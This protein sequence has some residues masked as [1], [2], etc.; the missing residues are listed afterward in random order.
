MRPGLRSASPPGSP[1]LPGARADL[2]GR[3]GTNCVSRC[4]R[5][6]HR[7]PPARRA[8]DSHTHAH[9]PL[10]TPE[11]PRAA[12]CS[13]EEGKGIAGSAPF[14]PSRHPPP[15]A[16]GR[17]DG[18]LTPGPGLRLAGRGSEP[19]AG[20]D[21][22]NLDKGHSRLHVSPFQL[23]LAGS[24]SVCPPATRGKG[25]RGAA[26]PREPP[27]PPPSPP[28]SLPSS[29][30]PPPLP[31]PMT[32]DPGINS[33]SRR[34]GRP[35]PTRCRSLARSPANSPAPPPPRL[36]AAAA[37][38]GAAAS[39]AR[40]SRSASL[41]LRLPDSP[42]RT[43]RQTRRPN[44]HRAHWRAPSA[45]PI[46]RTD[47]AGAPPGQSVAMEGGSRGV[48]SLPTCG[49]AGRGGENSLFSRCPRG[50]LGTS[51]F[52]C[53]Y[54]PPPPARLPTSAPRGG[55]GP[56]PGAAPRRGGL[57][58]SS[59]LTWRSGEREGKWEGCRREDWRAPGGAALPL[60]A[61][62]RCRV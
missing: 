13:G 25:T 22:A 50:G 26:A 8:P 60:P 2:S 32:K 34:R 20:L 53:C 21:G 56:G 9:L 51:R 62:R 23:S 16:L 43:E 40:R 49:G 14:S 31:S 6:A 48:V 4:P 61:R 52:P 3:R 46:G 11:P 58:L 24:A 36:R 42:S 7:F 18:E 30:P 38:A 44:R 33:R 27:S 15:P 1:R 59:R 17:S 35:K 41:R 19:P 37:P 57:K 39:S 54:R 47:A 29:L 5:R 28:P 12:G 55:A 10:P 45:A